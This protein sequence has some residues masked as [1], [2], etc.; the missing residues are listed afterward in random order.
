MN[1]I[2]SFYIYYLLSAKVSLCLDC[3]K[4]WMRFETLKLPRLPSPASNC[5]SFLQQLSALRAEVCL[6]LSATSV[7]SLD[8]FGRSAL[9]FA[10]E[11]DPAMVLLLIEALWSSIHFVTSLYFVQ[12][13]IPTDS[14][15]QTWLNLVCLFSM[16]CW[17][18]SRFKTCMRLSV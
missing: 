14:D 5:L 2:R 13:G 11:S 3:W 8:V 16:F 17:H 6:Q 15:I 12:Y 10:A 4:C 7:T 1:Q 18:S 9:H